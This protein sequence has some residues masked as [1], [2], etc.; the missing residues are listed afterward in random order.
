MSGERLRVPHGNALG[1]FQVQEV[2][3]R[4]LSEREQDHL[5]GRGEVLRADGEVGSQE[6]GCGS[7]RGE[8][9]VH[10]REVEHLLDGDLGDG[11]V[12]LPDQSQ[13]SESRALAIL[14]LHAEGG[15][16]I[17]AHHHVLE[18]SGFGEQEDELF[19][20]LDDDLLLIDREEAWLGSGDFSLKALFR[21]ELDGRPGAAI[22]CARRKPSRRVCT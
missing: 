21:L 1:S 10:E 13:S 3:E 17:S 8:Q 6:V 14:V 2:A 18:S 12:P 7:Y 20:V 22:R 16:E 19:P 11:P 4:L 5:H 9:V 15:V